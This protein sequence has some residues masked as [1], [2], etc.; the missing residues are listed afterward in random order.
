MT[1]H[2]LEQLLWSFAIAILAIAFLAAPWA[3]A[4]D[5][6]GCG[7]ACPGQASCPTGCTCENGTCVLR[8]HN[9]CIGQTASACSVYTCS[10]NQSL[11]D[12][13][14]DVINDKCNC[15]H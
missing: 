2:K 12:C 3:V 11:W 14:P 9:D 5:G 6:G 10:D 8:R 13:V 15:P 4:D 1:T 7:G